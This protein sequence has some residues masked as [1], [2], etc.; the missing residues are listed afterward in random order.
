MRRSEAQLR[1]QATAQRSAFKSSSL[2]EFERA[3]A[4]FFGDGSGEAA[5][6]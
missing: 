6:K 5:F 4:L 2:S 3:E 1:R